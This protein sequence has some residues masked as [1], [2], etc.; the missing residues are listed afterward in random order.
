MI[1]TAKKYNLQFTGLS[2]SNDILLQMPIWGHRGVNQGRFAKIRKKHGIKCLRE[3]H[4]TTTVQSIIRIAQ[5]ATTVPGKPHRIN[6]SGIGRKICGCPPCR[7]DRVEL[8]CKHNG[9]CVEAAK[10]L[11]DCLYP[12]WNPLTPRCDHCEYTTLEDEEQERIVDVGYDKET[13]LTFD[14][15][16]R[17]TDFAHGF[18]IFAS[19]E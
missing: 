19:E 18:R 4:K 12:K 17:L 5:R 14:P 1:K 3:N 16:F 10:A 11:L 6:P 7:R 8:G 15:S 9:R 2:I 13:A